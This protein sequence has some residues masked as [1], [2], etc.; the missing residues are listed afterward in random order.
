MLFD[1]V[2]RLA[3]TDERLRLARDIHDGVAQAC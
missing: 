3:T 2:R 1:D